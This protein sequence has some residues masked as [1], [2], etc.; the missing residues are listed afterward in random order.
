MGNKGSR[1][2]PSYE[3]VVQNH[4]DE[5][6]SV[7]ADEPIDLN[8]PL[9]L[10]NLRIKKI[11]HDAKL[12]RDTELREQRKQKKEALFKQKQLEFYEKSYIKF[13]RNIIPYINEQ[14]LENLSA[15]HIIIDIAFHNFS[16]LFKNLIYNDEQLD[17]Q[18]IDKVF[19]FIAT[20]YD[21]YKL[22]RITPM[23]SYYSQLYAKLYLPTVSNP[24]N[25]VAEKKSLC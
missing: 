24:D 16:A 25:Q 19:M 11:A 14:I 4:T 21:K 20:S 2:P 8:K 12:K 13:C 15:D 7:I 1:N 23:N 10:D 17:K 22:L 5:K 9:S 3:E 6:Q 18:Y